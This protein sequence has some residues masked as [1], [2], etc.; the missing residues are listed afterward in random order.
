MSNLRA[1][2]VGEKRCRKSGYRLPRVPHCRDGGGGHP[3]SLPP[4]QICRYSIRRASVPLL[5]RQ[6]GGGE[7]RGHQ[8]PGQHFFFFLSAGRARC[9]RAAPAPGRLSTRARLLAGVCRGYQILIF[10]LSLPPSLCVGPMDAPFWTASRQCLSL[11]LSLSLWS[12]RK[13]TRFIESTGG[14]P[15]REEKKHGKCLPTYRT[16]RSMER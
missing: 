8:F 16:L 7:D 12:F 13:D 10:S 9:C 14:G 4:L 15:S 2:R 1:A 5:P 11:S 6:G 3:R